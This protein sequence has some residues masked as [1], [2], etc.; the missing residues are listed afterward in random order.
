MSTEGSVVFEELKAALKRAEG[1]LLDCRVEAG[2]LDG[3]SKELL[4]RRGEALLKL[5]RHYLPE[6]SRSAIES[7]F[8]EIR[9]DLLGILA[10]R[11]AKRNE[12]QAH[13]DQAN[14]EI[15]R[16]NAGIDDVTRQLDEKVVLR[17]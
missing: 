6:I 2:R 7:T 14:E 10:K 4:D 17:E 11:E 13:L 9:S 1:T 15:E 5:A 3:Q 12:L 16:Q 8:K